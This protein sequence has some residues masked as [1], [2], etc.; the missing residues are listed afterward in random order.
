MLDKFAHVGLDARGGWAYRPL[1]VHPVAMR[2]VT[3]GALEEDWGSERA[4]LHCPPVY[5]IASTVRNMRAEGARGVLLV[6]DWGGA[7]WTALV[8]ALATRSWVWEAGGGRDVCS[9]RRAV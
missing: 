3:L 8:R 1:G 5:I 4:R 7:P 6:P 2:K 9:G